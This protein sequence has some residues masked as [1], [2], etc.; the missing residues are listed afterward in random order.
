MIHL[1]LLVNRQG[2]IRLMKWYEGFP[3]AGRQKI[4]KELAIIAIGRSSKLSNVVEWNQYKVIY[5]RYASLYF[6]ILCDKNDNELIMLELIQHFV[7][8]LDRYF[9][10]VC[11]LDII[12]NYHK[13][14][15]IIEEIL[16]A[17]YIQEVDKKV[18]SKL[19][20]AQDEKLEEEEE[21]EYNPNKMTD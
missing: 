2:K 18:I 13:A 16:S 11:E 9:V 21:E 7:E 17:G 4:V 5:K 14:Y 19:L 10:N 12:F 3:I 15:Y 8:C 6:I 1:M 20:T